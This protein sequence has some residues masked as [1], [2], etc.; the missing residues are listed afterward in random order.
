MLLWSPLKR[1][2]LSF[3]SLPLF[4]PEFIR[5]MP[6]HCRTCLPS[7]KRLG[8]ASAVSSLDPHPAPNESSGELGF[9]VALPVLFSSLPTSD[10]RPCNSRRA[11]PD[12]PNPVG[13]AVLRPAS[14]NL[15]GDPCR[16]HLPAIRLLWLL[17][18]VSL[19]SSLCL[20]FVPFSCTWIIG[21]L[22]DGCMLIFSWWFAWWMD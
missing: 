14:S 17:A 1:K 15:G 7:R 12:A 6:T 2:H 13:L 4:Q 11:Q 21:C 22:L 8:P 19:S 3:R 20:L 18:G 10:G 16:H 5:E 9:L